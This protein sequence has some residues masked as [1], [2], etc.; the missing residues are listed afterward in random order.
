MTNTFRDNYVFYD[1]SY[2]NLRTRNQILQLNNY[3]K[4]AK[5]FFKLLRGN[6][7]TIK[8]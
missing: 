5:V 7:D 4:M 3:K 6:R 1:E 2:E 8:V